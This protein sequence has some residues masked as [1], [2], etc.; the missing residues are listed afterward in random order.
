MNQNSYVL[1][2][3]VYSC[4]RKLYAS[5]GNIVKHIATHGE[6][7]IVEDNSGRRFSLLAVEVSKID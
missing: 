7:W 4:K 3:D 6:I 1:N 2:N 5:K